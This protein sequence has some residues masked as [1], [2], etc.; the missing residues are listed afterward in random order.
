MKNN[1]L[2]KTFITLLLLITSITYAQKLEKIKGSKMVTLTEVTLDSIVSIELY[3]DIDL[4][5][6]QGDTD[7]LTIY[8]DDNLHDVVDID[9]NGGKLSLSLLKR[10]S[11]KKKFELTLYANNLSLIILND[12]STLTNTDFYKAESL[13]IVM[14]NK[15]ELEC[16]FD[17]DLIVYEGN[18]SSDSDSTFKTQTINYTLQ[19]RADVKGVS[20]AE[21]TKINL[22]GKTSITLSGKSKETYITATGSSDIKIEDMLSKITEID[23]EDKST[24]YTNT[25]ENLSILAKDGSKINI[26]GKAEIDLVEFKGKAVLN[27]KE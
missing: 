27:K 25:S 18:D 19:D 11:S 7:R 17:A 15:S 14:N 5:L 8:A 24:V 20:N 21:I 12:D 26:Y 23:A 4:V 10:I 9:L 1:Y 2:S 22:D 13:N 3:K 16:L 6:K